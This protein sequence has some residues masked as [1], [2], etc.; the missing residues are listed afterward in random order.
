MHF[1]IMFIGIC[2]THMSV[3][4]KCLLCTQMQKHFSNWQ[5]FIDLMKFMFLVQNTFNESISPRKY[6]KRYF[7]IR[8]QREWLKQ[9]IAFESFS[10]NSSY[11]IAFL[12]RQTNQAVFQNFYNNFKNLERCL[13]ILES[14]A[15]SLTAMQL[16]RDFKF[17]C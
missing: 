2:C 12:Q 14:F 15:S 3:N 9:Y 17:V 1:L 5:V 10:Y 4:N 7:I 16:D 11:T 8:K 6:F 13:E